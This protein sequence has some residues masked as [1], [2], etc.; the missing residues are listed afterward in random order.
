MAW[1]DTIHQAFSIRPQILKLKQVERSLRSS[2]T[3]PHWYGA[4]GKGRAR[5]EF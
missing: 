2:T 4:E 1:A 5:K 3:Y